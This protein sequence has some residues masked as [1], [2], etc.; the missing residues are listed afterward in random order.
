VTRP[1]KAQSAGS[2][3]RPASRARKHRNLIPLRSARGE[4]FVASRL[5]RFL[6]AAFAA[7][8]SLSSLPGSS[9]PS[10]RR[11]PHVTPAEQAHLPEMVGPRRRAALTTA[12]S[13]SRLELRAP[14]TAA[15]SLT[16]APPALNAPAEQAHQTHPTPTEGAQDDRGQG[17]LEGVCSALDRLRTQASVV[18]CGGLALLAVN[19]AAPSAASAAGDANEAFCPPETESSPGFRAYLPDCR[20]YELA[21][22]PYTEGNPVVAENG[23]VSPDGEHL[24]LGATGAFAGAGNLWYEDASNPMATAYRL[25]RTPSGWRSEVLTPPATQFTHA[26]L[27]AASPADALQTTLWGAGTHPAPRVGEAVY[28]R[29][30]DGSFSLLG[31][32]VAPA[33]AAEPLGAYYEEL[34]FVGASAD[35]TRSLF[36]VAKQGKSTWPGDTTA[37]DRMSLYEYVYSGSPSPEPTLVG[38]RNEGTV[39]Q[40]AAEAADPHLN[41]AAELISQCGTALGSVNQKEGEAGEEH[42]GEGSLYNAVSADGETVFFTSQKC[43]NHPGEP[44]V[45][46]L[47]A[48]LAAAKTLAVSEPPLTGPGAVPGRLCTGACETAETV[49]A[50]RRLGF[51]QGASQDGSKVFFTTKQ[52]LLNSDTD[53]ENDLYMAEIEGH[54]AAAHLSALRQLSHDPTPAQPAEVQGVV[55]VSEDG[56][57]VYFVAKG[58]L[59]GP[60]AEAQSPQLGAD[61]LYVYDTATEQTAFVAT[62]L[63]PA[64][65]SALQAAEA[66]AK[67]SAIAT[68]EL[69]YFPAYYEALA[70]GETEEEASAAAFHAFFTRETELIQEL[71]ATSSAGT[72]AADRAVWQNQDNRPAQATPDGRYLLFLS[73]AHL[74]PGDT[75]AVPQLFRYDAAA[76]SILRVSI[77]QGPAAGNV[78]TFGAA[79]QIPSPQFKEVDRPTE[80]DFYRAISPDGQSV[81]F[82]SA[83][84][85]LPGAAPGATNL[86]EYRAGAVYLLSDGHDASK[87]RES[88][89]VRFLGAAGPSARDAFFTTA[90]P[91]VPGAGSQQSVYDARAAGGFPAPASP[92]SCRAEACRGL[93]A[94]SPA[95]AT[96]GSASFSGPGNEKPHPK[97]R[98]KRHR[99]RA[100]VHRTRP[101][102]ANRGGHK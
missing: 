69:A 100:E 64:E 94:Q 67:A 68:A 102:H 11:S 49:P 81:F 17:R 37:N 91:L 101:A 25:S 1:T 35:L 21:T 62:L 40:A 65:E 15:P 60:N 30:P 5:G 93:P 26:H 8:A 33:R 18:L 59:A 53:N 50:N 34:D 13:P 66:A 43:A 79:P 72:L 3:Q 88:P 98:G 74:T 45:T 56:S 90:D 10:P 2:T 78:A 31:P 6:R 46:E 24:L 57:H 44:P 82:T 97:H 80:A 84:P 70:H 41:E 63:T 76:E 23:A 22:P 36:T 83:A 58:V 7:R 51:F 48:R 28:L 55:R 96:A 92:S 87:T 19:L 61:N 38:V 20:A 14:R 29:R 47:Y 32:E 27:F 71:G 75:S 54:G 85:L 95:S 9:A 52:P 4:A 42:V 39:A 99:K 86:Y 16:P 89:T 77:G 12:A 73:S